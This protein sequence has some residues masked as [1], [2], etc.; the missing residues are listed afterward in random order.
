[1]TE[2]YDYPL[3]ESLIEVLK[4]EYRDE[5]IDKRNTWRQDCTLQYLY[6]KLKEEYYEVVEAR[7]RNFP[8][9]FIKAELVDMILVAS[10]LYER[11]GR[12]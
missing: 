12:E 7:E 9:G 8:D 1:M 3:S 6:K 4:Q 11:L 2:E 5:A 10:M